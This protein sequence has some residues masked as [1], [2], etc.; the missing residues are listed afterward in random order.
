MML[1]LGL[2]VF[3]LQ[4]LPYQNMQRNVDYRWPSNSRVGQRPALQFLGVED[5]KIT[6]SGELLP[7]ITGGT[8]SLLMLETMA[9]QGRAWPLIE[10]SGT[11]YGVFV[12]NSISQTKTDFFTDGR[13]RRIEF[14]IT[15]T[16]V[17]SSL[18]AMLGDLR[19]QAE[20][21]IGSAGEMANRAQSAIGGLFA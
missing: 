21:L 11:I 7:E 3:Q 6:L 8:L 9:D 18:S 4:T 19:Q 12:V 10:G 13:A 17:D 2:F 5:E 14:T 15:L 20:G 16:R 1:T